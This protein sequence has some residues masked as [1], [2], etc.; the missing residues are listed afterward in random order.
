MNKIL[1]LLYFFT[2]LALES[3]SHSQK[4]NAESCERLSVLFKKA[5]DQF[6]S[7]YSIEKNLIKQLDSLSQIC[8]R[9][10]L[11]TDVYRLIVVN[12][13]NNQKND[14]ILYLRKFHASILPI[15]TKEDSVNLAFYYNTISGAYVYQG[16]ESLAIVNGEKALV[17]AEKVKNYKLLMNIYAN[18]G[19]L[20]YGI[21]EFHQGLKFIRNSLKTKNENLEKFRPYLESLM[22]V[23]Y[24]GMDDFENA[25]A[26][27]Q[28]AVTG[29]LKLGDSASYY[30]ETTRLH[31]FKFMNI[32]LS[33]KKSRNTPSLAELKNLHS[34]IL[35][36]GDTT[37]I[38]NSY[39]NLYMYYYINEDFDQA[40]F[41]A[42]TAYNLAKTNENFEYYLN[43]DFSVPI[44]KSVLAK[45]DKF[46]LKC[47][48][49][50]DK[51]TEDQFNLES[52]EKTKDFIAKYNLKE[53][54]AKLLSSTNKNLQLKNT[55]Q[56]G[57]LIA[58]SIFAFL[59]IY[60]LRRNKRKE[61]QIVKLRLKAMQGQMNP[62]F[63]FNS[64][65][66]IN[67]FV[68]N[69]DAQKSQYFIGKFAKVMRLALQNSQEEYITIKQEV[70]FLE[71]YLILEKQRLNNFEFDFQIPND[72]ENLKIPP[73]IIQ[74]LIEN[75]IVHAFRGLSHEGKLIVRISKK[76]NKLLIEIIDNGWGI[77]ENI[78]KADSHISYSTKINN[79][80]LQLYT[81][82]K[83]II[84]YSNGIE[85]YSTPGTK[86]FFELPI[87]TK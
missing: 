1:V 45:Y 7:N 84:K 21:G 70:E 64:L 14:A 29:Y 13:T 48:E 41:Y 46:A 66:A 74:P 34:Q 20:S 35:E 42:K 73:F 68:T 59:A 43:Y 8:E 32:I 55:I 22:A 78:G 83:L 77:A 38:T 54:E 26:H 47:F 36:N 37:T 58:V 4:L 71:N 82:N 80:R 3:F 49:N 19:R 24:E 39:R 11:K 12:Q 75:A 72:L 17:I 23:G 76:E 86:A 27:Q 33:K 69:N 53:K 30:Y 67:N 79:E 61:V 10:K 18:L 63:L 85:G 40:T 57:L 81:K 65:N 9:K 51:F 31:E 16:E 52:K 28:K 6:N 5:N 2:I 15:K 44:I 50:Y 62:H 25:A 87:L 56:K 60:I